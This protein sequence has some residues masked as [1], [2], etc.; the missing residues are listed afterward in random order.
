MASTRP[1]MKGLPISKVQPELPAHLP[2]K[3]DPVDP[4]TPLQR[5]QTP[6]EEDERARHMAPLMPLNCL[7]HGL[8]Q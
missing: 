8:R 2:A 6:A 5:K 4:L 7:V 1:R 3:G